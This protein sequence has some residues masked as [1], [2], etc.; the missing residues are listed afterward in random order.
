MDW[1]GATRS[2]LPLLHSNRKNAAG[3]TTSKQTP[4]PQNLHS[5]HANI[6]WRS[7]SNLRA[8]PLE[9]WTGLWEIRTYSIDGY[10]PIA[11]QAAAQLSLHIYSIRFDK[12]AS[13]QFWSACSIYS[14]CQWWHTTVS[15]VDLQSDLRDRQMNNEQEAPA[16]VWRKADE[17]KM[18]NWR[19]NSP[20]K[21]VTRAHTVYS[22]V[23]ISLSTNKQSCSFKEQARCPHNSSL[24]I[25]CLWALC[26][27]NFIFCMRPAWEGKCS[28]GSASTVHAKYVT[29]HFIT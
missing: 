3:I 11:T 7:I 12:L 1:L 27:A 26:E 24:F 22:Q 8:S 19:L 16:E 29:G 18:N 6:I 20:N 13:R 23:N 25:S 10:W 21:L 17:F 4:L 2:K 14:Y 15:I 9:L 5:A 28:S